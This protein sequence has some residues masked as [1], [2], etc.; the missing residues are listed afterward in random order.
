M[1]PWT[2]QVENQERKRQ[3]EQNEPL[4]RQIQSM[5]PLGLMLFSARHCSHGSTSYSKM[6]A[7]HGKHVRRTEQKVIEPGTQ[8]IHS[9]TGF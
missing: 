6:D 1:P 3:D 9:L 5:H 4:R 8:M 2:R 7:I